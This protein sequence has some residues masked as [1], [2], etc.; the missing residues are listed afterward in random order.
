MEEHW[1]RRPRLVV[2][3]STLMAAAVLLGA[4]A[5]TDEVAGSNVLRGDLIVASWVQ[6]VTV[7]G[8]ARIVETLNWLGSTWPLASITATIALMLAWRGRWAESLL[9]VP[10]L[11]TYGLNWLL[12]DVARSPRPTTDH[13]RVTD[14]S[15]GFGF[16]SGHT[17]GMVVIA[18]LLL[19]VAWR[20]IERER[21]RLAVQAVILLLVAGMGFSRIYSGAHWPT[22]VLGG[23]L[24]GSFY[25]A[26][27]VSIFHAWHARDRAAPTAA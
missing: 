1:S 5:L 7:P 27:I 18:G 23:I 10:G 17:M 13:V 3:L 9:L 15:A 25:A 2:T 4:L 21:L 20:V 22:D 12:K 24:W 8:V 11:A 16:P 26:I 6:A 14:P 19:Y